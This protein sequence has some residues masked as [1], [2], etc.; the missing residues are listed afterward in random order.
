MNW[1]PLEVVATMK[2]VK[3][4]GRS[5]DGLPKFLFRK[6]KVIRQNFMWLYKIP[7][8]AKVCDIVGYSIYQVRGLFGNNFSLWYLNQTCICWCLQESHLSLRAIW[9]SLII[10]LHASNLSV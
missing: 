4:W 3:S 6:N 2:H 1:V 10:L 7:V 8:F 5:R 9:W